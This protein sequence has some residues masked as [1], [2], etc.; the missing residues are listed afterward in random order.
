MLGRCFSILCLLASL[1]LPGNLFAQ[2]ALKWTNVDGK[3]VVGEF[4]RMEG[5]TVVIK[6][7]NGKEAKV[8]LSSLSLESH[9]QAL[10]LSKPEAFN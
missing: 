2:D 4:V 9:L 10:K 3:E 7:E 6:L 1:S 8:P 5:K